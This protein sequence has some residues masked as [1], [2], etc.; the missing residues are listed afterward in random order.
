MSQPDPDAVNPVDPELKST[1]YC[2]AIAEGGQA[3]WDFLWQRY[4]NSD[5]A[6]EQR[7]VLYA[8]GKY[9]FFITPHEN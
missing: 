8:L 6:D 9:A 2:T 5:S 7:T 4:L 3:E 1:A